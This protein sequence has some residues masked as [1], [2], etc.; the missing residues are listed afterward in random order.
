MHS[1]D[2]TN[3]FSGVLCPGVEFI[4]ALSFCFASF[5]NFISFFNGDT[6]V[7][8]ISSLNFDDLVLIAVGA[9]ARFLRPKNY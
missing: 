5:S 8:L 2:F 1:D 4:F 9:G 3:F 6:V 7:P